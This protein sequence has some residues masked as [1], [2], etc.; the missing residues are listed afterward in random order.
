MFR[1]G[2][3]I[4]NIA[5]LSFAIITTFKDHP[6]GGD[7]SFV[8]LV[9]IYLISNLSYIIFSKRDGE[10]WLSLYINRKKLEEK[11]KICALNKEINSK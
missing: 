2:M 7:L 3:L 6:T 1:V 11:R 10:S 4:L 5:V 8:V 9:Y